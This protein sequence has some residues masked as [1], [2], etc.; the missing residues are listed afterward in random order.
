METKVI[1][2]SGTATAR[3]QTTLVS[4]PIMRPFHIERIDIRWPVGTQNY[5]KLSFFLSPDAEAPTAGEPTGLNLLREYGQVDYVRG[6][7]LTASLPHMILSPTSPAYLKVKAVND[8]YYDHAVD[9]TVVIR[10][11]QVQEVRNVA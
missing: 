2:F 1:S 9:V 6:D 4:Q 8:D 5:L 11:D 10:T 3:A 7:G